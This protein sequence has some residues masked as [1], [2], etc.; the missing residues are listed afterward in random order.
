MFVLLN[1]ASS[2]EVC[3]EGDGDVKAVPHV[4]T[5]TPQSGLAPIVYR[6][7]AMDNILPKTSVS[8]IAQFVDDKLFV[9]Q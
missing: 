1:M 3:C 4:D 5:K 9:H 8:E 2:Y 6:I 7:S